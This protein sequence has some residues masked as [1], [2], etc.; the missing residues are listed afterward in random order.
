M[1]EKEENADNEGEVEGKEK[2]GKE[3]GRIEEKY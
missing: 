2:V 1:R 3:K